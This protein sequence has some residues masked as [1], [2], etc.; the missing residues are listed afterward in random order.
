MSTTDS[1][2][3]ML[4]LWRLAGV[5]LLGVAAGV[6]VAAAMGARDES[7]IRC[8]GVVLTVAVIGCLP[9]VLG[10]IFG[11]SKFGLLALAA[12]MVQTL[13]GAG[14]TIGVAS[15]EGEARRAVAVGSC[16]GCFLVLMLCAIVAVVTI[17]RLPAGVFRREGGARSAG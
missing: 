8:A 7:L 2:P 14:L 17:N 10:P 5:G 12:S 13:A 15:M 16:A 6:G 4:L 9:A 1:I 11:A 3:R